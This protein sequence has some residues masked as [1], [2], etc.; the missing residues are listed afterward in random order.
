MAC[1]Q[2]LASWVVALVTLVTL[3]ALVAPCHSLA[4]AFQ[5]WSAAASYTAMRSWCRSASAGCNALHSLAVAVASSV[6]S[7]VLA[8]PSAAQFIIRQASAGVGTCRGTLIAYYLIMSRAL[9]MRAKLMLLCTS[10]AQFM[11]N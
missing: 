3:V 8:A 11:M 5:V 2:L 4:Q 1:L 7:A 6:C 10:C 9:F